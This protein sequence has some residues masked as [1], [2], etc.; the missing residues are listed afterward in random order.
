MSDIGLCKMVQPPPVVAFQLDSHRGD[1]VVDEVRGGEF[2]HPVLR[3]YPPPPHLGLFGWWEV[4]APQRHGW[5]IEN[6]RTI[7]RDRGRWSPR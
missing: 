4:A 1:V 3:G 5:V 2:S 6:R 7:F